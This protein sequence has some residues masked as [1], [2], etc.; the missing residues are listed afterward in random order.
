MALNSLGTSL[1]ICKAVILSRLLENA[2]QKSAVHENQ[3]LCLK[4]HSMQLPLK[5]QTFVLYY[6]GH[7]L[8][9]ALS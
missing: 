1:A 7:K 2:K 4:F 8:S 5:C 6:F 9:D 3:A